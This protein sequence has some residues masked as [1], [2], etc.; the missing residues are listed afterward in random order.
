[1]KMQNDAFG[2][3]NGIVS[4]ESNWGL[5]KKQPEQEISETRWAFIWD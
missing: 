2:F 4:I 5:A 1:M 3:L